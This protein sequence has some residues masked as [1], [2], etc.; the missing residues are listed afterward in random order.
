MTT[1]AWGGATAVSVVACSSSDAATPKA[2]AGTKKGTSTSSSGDDD[3]T[4]A[5]TSGN[6]GTSGSTGTS[7]G[8]SGG[9]DAGTDAN[10]SSGALGSNPKQITCGAA[11]CD[12]TKDDGTEICCWTDGKQTQAACGTAAE[13]GCPDGDDFAGYN[14]SCDE[15]ADCGD[16][17]VCC[18]GDGQTT[19][20]G[21]C[22][23]DV[24]TPQGQSTIQVCKTDKE[25]NEDGKDT[26]KCTKKTCTLD[27]NGL[28]ITATLGVCGAPESCK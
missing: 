23:N 4:S 2:D 3:D 17:E 8:T 20:A 26:I 14:I 15:A 11:T 10:A 28:N 6:N 22:E 18:F 9:T 19:C 27:P 5:G 13:G 24:G 25:C 16:G 7:G 12:T 21:N 1:L